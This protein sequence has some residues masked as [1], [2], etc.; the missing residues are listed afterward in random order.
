MGYYWLN[1]NNEA[2]TVQ[3]KGQ[4]C[5]LSLNKEEIY[6]VFV[7]KDWRTLFMEYLA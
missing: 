4:K 2:V 1:L 5:Q 3:D 7:T 6:V